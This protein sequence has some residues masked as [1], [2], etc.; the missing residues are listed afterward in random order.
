L[1]FLQ[2]LR[3]ALRSEQ[4]LQGAAEQRGRLEAG[5]LRERGIDVHHCAVDGTR[6]DDQ[7]TMGYRIERGT[8]VLK[9]GIVVVTLHAHRSMNSTDSV[10]ATIP[11]PRELDESTTGKLCAGP[12]GNPIRGKD[13]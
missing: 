5:Q 7:H 1:G 10:R 4:G 13:E 12:R 6:I 9:R 11:R 8:G 2:R 3:I